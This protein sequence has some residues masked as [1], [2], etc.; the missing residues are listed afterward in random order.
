M[1]E[2]VPWGAALLRASRRI[3]GVP[4]EAGTAGGADATGKAG[5]DAAGGR[6]GRGGRFLQPATKWSNS[7]SLMPRSIASISA[8]V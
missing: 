6:G 2:A 4:G 3:Q 8:L 1:T 7:P 5:A